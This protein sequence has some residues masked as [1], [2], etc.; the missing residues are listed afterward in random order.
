MHTKTQTTQPLQFITV[1]NNASCVNN[2]SNE[3]DLYFEEEEEDHSMTMTDL[4]S[5]DEIL[6]GDDS[7]SESCSSSDDMI[8]F[9]SADISESSL[10][11]E[12][13]ENPIDTLSP[14]PTYLIQNA[15]QVKPKAQITKSILVDIPTR[16][17]PYSKDYTHVL[18]PEYDPTGSAKVYEKVGGDQFAEDSI[19]PKINRLRLPSDFSTASITIPSNSSFDLTSAHSVAESS[20]V[21]FA[22]E[23]LERSNMRRGHASCDNLFTLP[24]YLLGEK[25]E[26]PPV[27]SHISFEVST[28]TSSSDSRKNS[29]GSSS[30]ASRL[31]SSVISSTTALSRISATVLESQAY[32]EDYDHSQRAVRVG[33]IK[34]KLRSM[35]IQHYRTKCVRSL[36]RSMVQYTKLIDDSEDSTV[37]SLNTNEIAL[38]EISE[39]DDSKPLAKGLSQ[40]A[41]E[42][43]RDI[44]CFNLILAILY[45]F[46]VLYKDTIKQAVGGAEV[47]HLFGVS[48]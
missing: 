14:Y 33:S 44:L 45:M 20:A 16:V 10:T 17:L 2:L 4:L 40:S 11:S 13:D 39:N 48:V 43:A 5:L 47:N 32:V 1:L 31:T 23:C 21:T 15:Y 26:V 29:A 25:N 36:R 24:K 18:Y 19:G 9:G 41:M 28:I 42:V 46:F 22:E 35:E 34:R 12:D 27:D 6:D 30:T 3:N 8:S 7:D 37:S 38:P